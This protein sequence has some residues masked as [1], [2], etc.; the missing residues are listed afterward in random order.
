MVFV[1]DSKTLLEV[2]VPLHPHPI[3]E[4]HR[5]VSDTSFTL[6]AA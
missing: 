2:D 6:G 1:S 4:L 5:P 3:F